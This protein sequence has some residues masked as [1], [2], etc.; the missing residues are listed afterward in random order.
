MLSRVADSIYWMNRYIER[1]ENVARFIEVNQNLSLGFHQ[2]ISTQW[3]PLVKTTGDEALFEGLYDD[4]SQ[5]NVVNFLLFDLEN[6]N[7]IASCLNQAR[8]NA[9]CVRETLSLAVWEA[10]NKFYLLFHDHVSNEST[11]RQ[12]HGLLDQVKLHSQWIEGAVESTMTHRGAWNV[13]K[14]GRYLERADKTS[15]ILDVKYY[16]LL[17]RSDDVGGELDVV[18]WS[19]L[20]NSLSALQMYRRWNGRIDPRNVVKFLILDPF[21]PRSIQFCLMQSDDALHRLSGSAPN[22]FSNPAEQQIGRLR[23]RNDYLT[24]DDIVQYGLHEFIDDLQLQLNQLGISIVDSFYATHVQST[25]QLSS[26]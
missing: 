3:A 22:S 20:L 24:V 6:P 15:R 9:R 5:K 7:S 26:L 1:A 19:A 12:P 4:Y 25:R 10:I 23:A 2:G 11:L 14:L 8:E 13:S 16:M 17:P 18:Q 21:F